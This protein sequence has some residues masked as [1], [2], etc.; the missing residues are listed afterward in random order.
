MGMTHYS[1]KTVA[2]TAKDL[3]L[4]GGFTTKE[5][6]RLLREMIPGC[7]T[8]EKCVHFYRWELRREGYVL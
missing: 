1:K 6:V 3:I 5:I 7:K 8:T 4:A 2:E